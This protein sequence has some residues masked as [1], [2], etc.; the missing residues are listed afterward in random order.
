VK[1]L[2]PPLWSLSTIA[3]EKGSYP[4]LLLLSPGTDPGPEL[5]VLAEKHT[6]AGFT[7]VSLGQGHVTQAEWALEAACR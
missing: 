3:Q 4:V 5:S 1:D 2:A 7:E 6:S